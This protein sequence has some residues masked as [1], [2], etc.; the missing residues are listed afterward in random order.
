MH[1]NR[2]TA[3]SPVHARV[4]GRR[5]RT[6]LALPGRSR[7][8]LHR[9]RHAQPPAVAHARTARRAYTGGYP[10][11]AAG[12]P[13]GMPV[14]TGRTGVPVPAR[15]IPAGE[16]PYCPIPA[17]TRRAP[18]SRAYR[19]GPNPGCGYPR[20]GRN[21]ETAGG[22]RPVPIGDTYLRI[23]PLRSTKFRTVPRCGT[24]IPANSSGRRRS[25]RDRCRAESAPVPERARVQTRRRAGC[26]P[27]RGQCGSPP[28]RRAVSCPA[29][30]CQ[31]VRSRAGK[32]VPPAASAGQH[33]H[34]GAV[35]P[36][37]ERCSAACLPASRGA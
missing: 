10:R 24:Q 1:T 11:T 27:R 6:A 17:G 19:P 28:L 2:R 4:S 37:A 22:Y 14:R 13:S 7:G 34:S 12:Y 36:G 31:A 16:R 33:R 32:S 30:S 18:R 23:E 8:R 35:Q 9:G 5:G 29:K 25:T 20:I 21:P 15:A 3:A 26:R